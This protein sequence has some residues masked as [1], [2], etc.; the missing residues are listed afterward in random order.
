MLRAPGPAGRGHGLLG[1]VTL[2]AHLVGRRLR[3]YAICGAVLRCGPYRFE[4]GPEVAELLRAILALKL[5]K[6]DL[7][8]APQA[9]SLVTA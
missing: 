4:A 8:L 1:C 6:S 2:R 9:E 5:A 3:G 7:D